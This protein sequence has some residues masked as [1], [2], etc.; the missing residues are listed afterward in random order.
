MGLDLFNLPYLLFFIPLIGSSVSC[1]FS[2]G[3]FNKSVLV[4]STSIVLLLT[5]FLAPSVIKN[6]FLSYSIGNKISLITSEFRINF[7][8]IFFLFFVFLV[9]LISL[10]NYN[11]EFSEIRTDNKKFF[12]AIYLINCFSIVGILVSDNIFNLYIYLELYALTF[13]SLI[14]NYKNRILSDVAWNYF[15]S[16]VI[17]SMLILL[18]VLSL[19]FVLGTSQISSMSKIISSIPAT[20]HFSLFLIFSMFGVGVCIKFF[21]FWVYFSQIRKS[22]NINNALFKSLLFIHIYLGTYLLTKLIYSIFGTSVILDFFNFHYLFIFLGIVLIA[23]YSSLLRKQK[24]LFYILINLC[25]IDLGYIFMNLGLNNLDSLTSMFLFL[26]NYFLVNFFIFL[27]VSFLVHNYK[28]TNVGFLGA[29]QKYR[30]VVMLIFAS[31]LF[32]PVGLNFL[33]DWYY[34]RSVFSSGA[35]YLL[36][37]FLFNK[38]MAGFMVSKVY[39]V[40]FPKRKRKE[41]TYDGNNLINRYY[42]VS[43]ASLFSFM[44]VT[45]IFF[46][47]T[48]VLMRYLG[49]VLGG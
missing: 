38:A 16:G 6:N 2:R 27:L 41:I 42:L 5:V 21:T 40:L 22:Q 34:L 3:K 20:H 15:L 35:H 8:N 23:Y 7:V 25:L 29:F 11:K 43:F 31:K 45:S 30:V 48:Q 18:S 26:S 33:G 17:S 36:L 46:T 47:K 39:F 4:G 44:C 12:S 28:N 14:S 37:I 9:K 32:M 24:N 1:L 10:I 13:Y 49:R 19:Y